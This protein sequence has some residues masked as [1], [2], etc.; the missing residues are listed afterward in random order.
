M[1]EGFIAPAFSEPWI[2]ELETDTVD[3]VNNLRKLH[4]F[5]PLRLSSETS[6]VAKRYSER[7]AAVK[8]LFQGTG[9]NFGENVLEMPVSYTIMTYVEYP[10]SHATIGSPSEIAK[11]AADWSMENKGNRENVLDPKYSTTCLGVTVEEA[12]DGDGQVI[13]FTQ[14]FK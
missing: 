11:E 12:I 1:P 13:Y 5:R 3:A 9:C 6:N 2:D 7:V 8:A 4:K 14:H 10:V